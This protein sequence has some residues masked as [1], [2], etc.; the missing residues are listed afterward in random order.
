MTDHCPACSLPTTDCEGHDLAE[1]VEKCRESGRN[2]YFGRD[3]REIFVAKYIQANPDA[4]DIEILAATRQQFGMAINTS[5]VGHL[6]REALKGPQT[7]EDEARR[8]ARR[9]WF[10]MR[11]CGL[12]EAHLV[13]GRLT[14]AKPAVETVDLE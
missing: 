9:L 10:L 14:L 5:R 4:S 8:C 13:D 2:R 3:I 1:F 11:Q 7:T 12:T 6:R